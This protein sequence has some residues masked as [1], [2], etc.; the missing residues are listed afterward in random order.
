MVCSLVWQ[1]MPSTLWPEALVAVSASGAARGTGT[2]SG[3]AGPGDGADLSVP[4]VLRLA[5]FSPGEPVLAPPLIP[6][7]TPTAA[8]ATTATAPVPASQRRRRRRR[9][10]R[11]LICASFALACCRFLLPLA[12]APIS[13]TLAPTVYVRR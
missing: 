10:S 11:A 9:A 2:P 12:T 3:P 8:A 5:S 1:L 13:R 6:S 7:V 4:S